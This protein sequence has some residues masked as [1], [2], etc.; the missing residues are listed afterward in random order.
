MGNLVELLL[1]IPQGS[2]RFKN[3]SLLV[4]RATEARMRDVLRVAPEKTQLVRRDIG[5]N[6]HT[7]LRETS[8]KTAKWGSDA[9]MKGTPKWTG[10]FKLG[11]C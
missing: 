10:R 5:K 4:A 11:C 8:R 7:C 3:G 6:T 2:E 9:K 1:F